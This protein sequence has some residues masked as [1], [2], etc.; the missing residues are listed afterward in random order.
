ME[1]RGNYRI[2]L[3]VDRKQAR[4]EISGNGRTINNQRKS[5]YR[6]VVECSPE[7]DLNSSQRYPLCFVWVM[8]E[9]RLRRSLAHQ[10]SAGIRRLM[11]LSHCGPSRLVR[12][13]KNQ[14]VLGR[15]RITDAFRLA[16]MPDVHAADHHNSCRLSRLR[17][18]LLFG[19]YAIGDGKE[20]PTCAAV[21]GFRRF[22]PFP[23]AIS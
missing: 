22:I 14:F 4:K 11:R 21:S 2:I 16:I 9:T 13:N 8:A 20:L 7:P 10:L 12:L 18:A 17:Q 1:S 3:C 6:Q 15:P 5:K 23:L 19:V